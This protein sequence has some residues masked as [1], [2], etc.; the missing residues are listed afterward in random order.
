MKECSIF[1]PFPEQEFG[2]ELE[3]LANEGKFPYRSEGLAYYKI[4]EEFV[5]EWIAHAGTEQVFD[6]QGKA[7]YQDIVNS[8]E[9]LAYQ[10]PAEFNEKNL[11]AV[12]TQFIFTVTCFHEMVG[13]IV[14]YTEKPSYAGYRTLSSSSK[15]ANQKNGDD[16]HENH[17]NQENVVDLQSYLSAA[18]ITASTGVQMPALVDRFENFFGIG[19]GVPQW[20]RP[21]WDAFQEQLHVQ[22]KKVQKADKARR[23]ECKTFDPAH[24]ECSISV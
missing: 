16:G 18:V 5:T 20:E 8:T 13:T 12:L 24:F 6:E 14:D 22:S 1:Q 17:D 7:F 9:N 10:V 23:F 4:V 21:V 19:E 11:I 15:S 2:N 3:K